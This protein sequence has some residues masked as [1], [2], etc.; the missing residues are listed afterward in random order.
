MI[1]KIYGLLGLCAR[2][3][4]VVS[5]MDAVSDEVK[6]NKV[7]LLIIAEDASLKTVSNIEYLAKRKK[8]PIL[9]IGTIEHNSK[10]IGKQNRA[11]IGI[12]DK[13]ISDG[14]KK[15][16]GGEVFGEIKNL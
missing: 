1:N 9:V 12:K 8:I 10:A 2:A 16:C 13:N 11:I 14:I 5:G 4:K 6:K 7:K 3:G 15:I